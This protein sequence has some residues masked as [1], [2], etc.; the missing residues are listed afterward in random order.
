MKFL[1]NFCYSLSA[2]RQS[3]MSV[4]AHVKAAVWEHLPDA[5]P[6]GEAC[7]MGPSTQSIFSLDRK[8]LQ[9]Q[10][11][12]DLFIYIL[13]FW[14]PHTHQLSICIMP[15]LLGP[16]RRDS[17]DPPG[18]SRGH[19][20]PA[21]AL[22]PR[23]ASRSHTPGSPWRQMAGPVENDWKKSKFWTRVQHVSNISS[24]KRK[25]LKRKALSVHWFLWRRVC[26]LYLRSDKVTG[27]FAITWPQL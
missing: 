20:L 26:L 7:G 25:E 21:Q 4:L 5:L 2:K 17:E 15:T 10:T 12:I 16:L 22:V 13:V 3:P 19:L 6:I 14:N 23:P 8:Q 11:C 18:T 24:L 9:T 1:W 27:A